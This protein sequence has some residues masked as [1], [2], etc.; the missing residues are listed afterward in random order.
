MFTSL[1]EINPASEYQNP[2]S[3]SFAFNDSSINDGGYLVSGILAAVAVILVK[4]TSQGIQQVTSALQKYAS[5]L[6]EI[7]KVCTISGRSS[8]DLELDNSQLLNWHS[9]VSDKNGL[10]LCYAD[11]DSDTLSNGC[12]RDR[13]F[14]KESVVIEAVECAEG[15][16]PQ[17]NCH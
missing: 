12:A 14:A 9:D 5:M 16:W 17:W 6:A 7:D 2:A 3:R 15:D 13:L 8:D 11:R 1:T 10:G 4:S